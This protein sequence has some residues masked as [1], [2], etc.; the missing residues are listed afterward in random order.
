MPIFR[1]RNFELIN[2]AVLADM[3]IAHECYGEMAAD[4]CNVILVT[5]GITNSHHAAGTVT[6]D[7]RK[8]WWN[9]VIGPR[10][11]FDTTR[12]CIVSSN[13]LDSSYGSTGPRPG[14]GFSISPP[15]RDAGRASCWRGKA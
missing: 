9:E 1:A 3:E 14:A 10:K 13:I 5:H 6:S 8:G 2:G 11:V 15:R 12:Y 7:R 4:K